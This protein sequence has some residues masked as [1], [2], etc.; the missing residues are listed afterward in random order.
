MHTSARRTR[1]CTMGPGR[2]NMDG[3]KARRREGEKRTLH[4]SSCRCWTKGGCCRRAPARSSPG[5]SDIPWNILAAMCAPGVFGGWIPPNSLENAL[6]CDGG[7]P[8][9]ADDGRNETLAPTLSQSCSPCVPEAH[10]PCDPGELRC[11]PKVVQEVPKECFGSLDSAEV[12]T[13]VERM[14]AKS[15]PSSPTIGH[16]WPNSDQTSASFGRNGP[17]LG[18]HRPRLVGTFAALTKFGQSW[19]KNQ[20]MSTN[21]G[22]SWANVG[23]VWP[24]FGRSGPEFGQ[25]A[26]SPP[27][28]V[29]SGHSLPTQGDLAQSGRFRHRAEFRHPRQLFG[30][31]SAP[32]G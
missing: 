25:H 12:L 1:V 28:W 2:V 8:G 19:P 31:C 17:K 18:R 6:R 27:I 22:R 9:E 26:R 16:N 32:G 15:L 13:N 11:C 10:T 21:I 29:E 5:P 20:P 3:A 30:N 14:M 24:T 23:Q 4:E 7:A